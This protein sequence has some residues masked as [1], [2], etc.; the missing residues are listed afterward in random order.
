[1]SG[2]NGKGGKVGR[3]PRRGRK[4][5]RGGGRRVLAGRGIVE[6]EPWELWVPEDDYKSMTEA[7]R[8]ALVERQRAL[9]SG[10]S[11]ARASTDRRPRRGRANVAG[12]LDQMTTARPV[13]LALL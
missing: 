13:Q 2:S 11:A 5:G 9:L 12:A 4:V 8:A 10:K 1:M 6:G 3:G 7:E